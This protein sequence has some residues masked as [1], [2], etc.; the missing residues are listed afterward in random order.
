MQY[1]RNSA[2]NPEQMIDYLALTGD[3]ADN[4]PGVGGVGPKTATKWLYKHQNLDG[5]IAHA[6][7][8][9]GKSGKA[10]QEALPKLPV[11]KDLV[12]IRCDVELDCTIEQLKIAAPKHERLIAF[13]KEYGFTQWLK[14]EFDDP[15]ASA[16][17]VDTPAALPVYQLILTQSSLDHWLKKL[18]SADYFALDIETTSLDYMQAQIVGL[19][20]ADCCRRFC[21]FA[22]GA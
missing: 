3:S 2:C 9:T 13:Y 17:E 19:S 7:T 11:Y 1:K 5:V 10:L 6:D 22:F 12:T 14:D 4:I 15:I 8:I 21:I 16:A 18:K 20:F